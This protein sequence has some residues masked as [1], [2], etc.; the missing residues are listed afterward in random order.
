MRGSG[1]R[2]AL[3]ARS[4][5]SKEGIAEDVADQVVDADSSLRGSHQSEDDNK[6]PAKIGERI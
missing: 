1:K 2:S 4:S 5:T 6:A 3:C